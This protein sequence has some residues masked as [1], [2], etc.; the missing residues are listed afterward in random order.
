MLNIVIFSEIPYLIHTIYWDDFEWN[1]NKLTFWQKNSQ[2]LV[3]N[4]KNNMFFKSLNE[5]NINNINQ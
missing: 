5:L 1:K 2:T 3:V 4:K